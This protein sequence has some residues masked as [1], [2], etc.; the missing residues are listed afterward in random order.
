MQRLPELELKAYRVVNVGKSVGQMGID[1]VLH[2]ALLKDVVTG[3]YKIF[4]QRA[5]QF[6]AAHLPLPPLLHPAFVSPTHTID[7][8]CRQSC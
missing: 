3:T 6:I 4:I 8:G 1:R 2:G 5:F 7:I